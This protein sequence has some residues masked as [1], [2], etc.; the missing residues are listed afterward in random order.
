MSAAATTAATLSRRT[1]SL[2]TWVVA[3][4]LAGGAVLLGILSGA[5]GMAGLAGSVFA[6]VAV[7]LV[8]ALWRRPELSPVVILVAALTIEQ[9]PFT[10]GQPGAMG[11]GVTPSDFTDRLPLFHGLGGVHVSPADVLVLTLLLIWL[12][13]RGTSQTVAVTRSPLTYAI[14]A[15]LVAVGVGV[16]VGQAHHGALR[17]SFTEV[18][19]Y[20]YL[21]VAYLVATVFATR[22]EIL[23]LAMWALVLGSGFKAAQALYS[24]LHVRNQI[25]RPDFIVGHEEALFF[26]L[27]VILTLSLWL[28]QIPGRLRT[29]AT[30]L[31]PLVF[32]ADLVNTRRAAWLILGG[33]LIAL[34]VV[35]MVAVPA[36]RH[37]MV[38]TLA[39]VTVI[40][41]FYFPAYWNHTGAL[42]GPARAVKSAVSPN[43]RDESSDVYRVKENENLKF[44]IREGGVLGRGFGLPIEDVSGIQNISKIDPLILYI[45]H[46][47]VFYIFMRMGLLGAIAFW[48]LLGIAIITGCRLVRSRNREVALFGALLACALVGYAL[49]GYN[50]Q[51]FFMYRIAFVIGTLLG[52]G[53]AARRLDGAGGEPAP[54]VAAT[55]GPVPATPPRRFSLVPLRPPAVERRPARAELAAPRRRRHGRIARLMSL[56]LLPI[57]I[58]FLIWLFLA[59]TRSSATMPSERPS[60]PTHLKGAVHE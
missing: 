18:R 5:L 14:G 39:V 6:V 4:L 31:L 50:D 55:L 33:A 43:T 37:F 2:P 47:G 44:N 15:L 45:P 34:T 7:A 13:K 32:M 11:P 23:R 49:E 30:M 52:L 48:S 51:G 40:S 38:R 46:N 24:F 29:T 36:R 16:V 17:T 21:A 3:A 1:G 10:T 56:V 25:P 19:P 57:A 42:A 41:A 12:L 27:F 35:T 53:E 54:A 8:V 9:F 60:V 59:G 28:F 20:F 58:A 26:A 22:L